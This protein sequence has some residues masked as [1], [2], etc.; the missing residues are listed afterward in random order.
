MWA[1]RSMSSGVPA[2]CDGIAVRDPGMVLHS[3]QTNRCVPPFARRVTVIYITSRKGHELATAGSRTV[4]TC[5]N[6]WISCAFRTL[7]RFAA[8]RSANVG[9][10]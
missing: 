6:A 2:L 7:L 3:D 4:C 8:A 1:N 9:K 10:R 5:E